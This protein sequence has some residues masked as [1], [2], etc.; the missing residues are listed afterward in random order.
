VIRTAQDLVPTVVDQA[1]QRTFK[2]NG[3]LE[4]VAGVLVYEG[5]VQVLIDAG[6][7]GELIRKAMEQQGRTAKGG[8]IT[9]RF[10]GTAVRRRHDAGGD[11]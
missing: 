11:R 6:G 2:L 4:L 9:V 3:E 5:E 1:L 7:L 10:R 8:P